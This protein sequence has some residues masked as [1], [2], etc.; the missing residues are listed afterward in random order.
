M[1][2][3][4]RISAFVS[5]VSG[6]SIRHRG[7]VLASWLVLVAACVIAGS[8][9]GMNTIS[10]ADSQ[11]GESARA[12]ELID[13]A[14]M[15][16]AP[17]EAIMVRAA[18]PDARAAATAGLERRL[19][20]VS[21]VRSITPPSE[22]AGTIRDGGR[23]ALTTV[24]L[25]GTIDDAEQTVV[26]VERAVA[27]TRAAHDGARID[28]A[29]DGSIERGFGRVI[30]EDFQKAE[31]LSLP[32]TLVIL[33][34]TFGALVAAS[35]P[36]LLGITSAAAALGLAGPISQII[37]ADDSAGALVLLMGLAVG[38]DYSLFC[39][40]R[41]REERAA[42]RSSGD[43]LAITMGTV[44]RAVAVAGTTVLIALAG[45]LF[46]GLAVFQSM[47][48][49]AITVVAIAVVGS[50]TVLP[51]TLA[52]LGD[53]IDRGRLPF[54]GRRRG[55]AERHGGGAASAAWGRFA[56]GVTARPLAA[57][58][59]GVAILGALAI[60]ALSM[61]P[62]GMEVASM[63]DSIPVVAAYKAIEGEF[64]GASRAQV[65]VAGAGLRTAAAK[66]GLDELGAA[67]IRATGGTGEAAIA[68]SRDGRTAIVDVPMPEGSADEVAATTERLRDAVH[69]LASGF[70]KDAEVAV[71]GWQ[72]GGADFSDRLA[73]VTP[74][75]VAL[76]LSLAFVLLVAAFRSAL[77]A[78][79]VI[80]LNVLSV[81]AAYGILVLVFQ[82]GW[83][84]QL[85]GF[86]S[87]GTVRDWLPLFLFV[88][89][90]GLSMDYTILVLERIRELRSG[91]MTA[92]RA[93]AAGV[94]STAGTVTS[95]AIVMVAVFALFGMMRFM[96]MKQLGVGLAAA[97]L[98]DATVVRG[99]LLPATV[100]ALGD[101]WDVPGARRPRA[102]ATEAVTA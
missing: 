90:F 25:V 23:T 43:A 36:L 53:R 18:D 44:G 66:A 31:L 69:P 22:D 102:R 61:K 50:L 84:E 96:D 42:G 1:P 52:L 94:A 40:R 77:L 93:A 29:G 17:S 27:A 92:R 99:V 81:A 57:L 7:L 15:T 63:P 70:G 68:T 98:L 80:A 59:A 85:L 32:L 48:I 87:T 2:T 12:A 39:I 79:C 97:I 86:T 24:Q 34:F 41:E 16:P 88:L 67:A 33:L 65:V 21:A 30:D 51:A 54:V 28:Q 13:R 45:F 47:A 26:P 56:A 8:L 3:N 9:T 74:I 75:V 73:T 38:V 78:V 11:V 62:A 71:G 19:E 55:A 91:G 10:D 64:P 58:V 14:G 82:H 37:P 35:V 5:R 20:R 72:A 100:A 83:G 6:W 49:G 4:D 60:P 95:A 76:V 101:R 46:S 89:L